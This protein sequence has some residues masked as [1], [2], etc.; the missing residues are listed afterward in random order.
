IFVDQPLLA[1]T[2]LLNIQL[3]GTAPIGPTFT[4]FRF[5]TVGGLSAEGEAPDGEVEDYQVNLLS[6]VDL[7]LRVTE[8]PNPVPLGSN[9]IYSIS[10][11]NTGPSQANGVL[12]SDALPP[13]V[14]FVGVSPS[15]GSCSLTNIGG[16]QV[17]WC[18]LGS[19]GVGQE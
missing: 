16:A 8:S 10:I 2:N 19:L 11:S 6:A 13:N 17:M 7:V 18:D 3:P 12:L 15:Q 4:R 9:L 1:G 14:T 5:S